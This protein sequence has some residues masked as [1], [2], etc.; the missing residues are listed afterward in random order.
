MTLVAPGRV[1]CA[2]ETANSGNSRPELAGPHPGKQAKGGLKLAL[3]TSTLSGLYSLPNWYK[4][5]GWP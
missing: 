2:E 3:H 5:L 1:R 4:F